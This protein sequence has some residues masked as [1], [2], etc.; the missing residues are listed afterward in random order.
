MKNN[1]FPYHQT[2]G[3][4]SLKNRARNL[5][6]AL[7]ASFIQQLKNT[8][9][10][11]GSL[12]YSIGAISS[13]IVYSWIANQTQ[14]LSRINYLL[15]GAPFMAIWSGVAFRTGWSLDSEI[16]YN[17]LEF[18]LISRTPM[19]V[20]LM[21]KALAQ[22]AYALPVGVLSLILM[23]LLT[24]HPP[25]AANLPLFLISICFI[26]T[27]IA[28]VSLVFAPVLVL[29]GGRAGFFNGILPFGIILSGFVFPPENLPLVFRVIS[30]IM[31]TSW[32]MSGAWQS[33]KGPDSVWPVIF[34]WLMCIL[35]SFLL[36]V[37]TVYLFKKIED[38]IRISGRLGTY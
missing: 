20:V 5:L 9:F 3:V 24:H 11:V 8:S 31:P 35:T 21:G 16:G 33:I 14:D 38:R 36:F 10:N 17:T 27:G 25:A 28:I 22:L 34:T 13:I 7:A 2:I 30:W 12:N 37:I 26:L 1:T 15:A 4:L 23:S 18:A 19:V 29:F 6:R 32:A